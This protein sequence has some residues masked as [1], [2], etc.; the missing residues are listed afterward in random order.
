MIATYMGGL[1]E[2]YDFYIVAAAAGTVWPKLFFPSSFDPVLALAISVSSVGVAYFARPV[3]AIIFGHVSDKYGR[4][5]TM[6]WTLTTMGVSCLLTAILPAYNVI[7]MSAIVLVFIFRF[8]VGLGLG[9]ESGSGYSWIME[10][11]PNSK[12]RGF[13]TSWVQTPSSFARGTAVFAFALAAAA[14][15]PAAYLEWGWRIPFVLGALGVFLAILVRAK[16]MESPLF[17]RLTQRREVLKYPAFEVIKREGRRIFTMLWI[18]IY[19]SMIAA[20][21]MLPYSVSYLVKMG[22]DESFANLSITWAAFAAAAP[23]VL[24]P[25]L[26]DHI[27]R[28]KTLWLSAAIFIPSMCIYFPLLNTLNPLYIIAAQV[29]LYCSFVPAVSSN[30]TMFAENFPTKYRASGMGI[31]DQLA[32]AMTGIFISFALPALLMTYGVIGAALPVSLI[33]IGVMVL[34]VVASLFVRETKGIALE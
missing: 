19:A 1:V 18:N 27:G 15:A 5:R 28:K 2:W 12:Y 10:A 30:R 21:V 32:A 9:G 13:W 4:R 33:S 26:S 16:L 31:T 29:L 22:V 25:L 23:T 6:V 8:L 7:G 14:L 3:G 34:G 17:Q 24:G 20:F 11:R